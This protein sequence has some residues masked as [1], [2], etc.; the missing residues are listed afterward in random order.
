MIRDNQRLINRLTLIIDGFVIVV[1][2][3]FAYFLK[4]E[5]G[6]L[7]YDEGLSVQTY[8]TALYFLVPG[9][10]ILY[11]KLDL[12]STRRASGRKREL[13]NVIKANTLGALIFMMI[14]YLINQPDFSRQMIFIFWGVCICLETA[15]RNMM[16]ALMMFWWKKGY[17]LKYVLLIGYSGSAESYINKVLLNPQWGYVIRG[18]LDDNVERGTEY[19]GIKVLGTIDN[20]SLIL[21]ENK[22]DEIAI[23]LPLGQYG[24]LKEIVGLC[25][26]S[27]VHTKFIP[28]YAGVIPNRPYTEDIQ[29]LPVINIRRV[30]LN[31][32]INSVVKRLV[33]IVGSAVGIVL[34]SPI[35]IVSAIL[36]KATSD[37]PVI[38]SQ[39]RVGLHNK[40]FRMYKFRTMIEQTEAEEAKGWTTKDDPRVTKIGRFLRK[41]SL[42]ELPQLFNIFI[43]QMSL[44]GPRPERPQFVEKFREEIPRYM[45]KHQVRPGLTGWAQINGLRGDTSI[46]K[47]IEHDLY[48]IENWTLE[49]DIKI[50]LLTVFRGFI[51]KNAY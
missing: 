42:D 29:G 51:N 34:A 7:L 39:E 9:Y 15:V 46:E 6:L 27:G 19:K 22:L 36:I 43:G 33:D 20:L 23:T 48:Y 1:S 2:Y 40:P 14:L 32:T 26:K 13:L 45:I 44:V 16:R 50:L 31:N 8:M 21:P 3:L 18:I 41:T 25:E 30:P 17:N 28:D 10:L 12:Y 24:R 38:F 35:M 47:R 49:F 37:G 5:S 11:S 4:F